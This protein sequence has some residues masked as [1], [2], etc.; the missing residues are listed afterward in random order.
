MLKQPI[1]PNTIALSLLK[2]ESAKREEAE[3]KPPQ[4]DRMSAS[5]RCYRDRWATMQGLP[6]DYGKG[7]GASVLQ[8]FRLGHVIEDE[9]V[10]LL[11]EAGF[12][13][14]DQQREVGE[15]QWIG[16][17]DGIVEW[18]PSGRDWDRVTSLLEI[19]SANAKQFG[20]CQE[21]GYEAWKPQYAAQLHAYMGYIPEVEEALVIV[22]NK[23]TSEIYAER[24]LFDL[25]E[26]ERLKE[27]SRIVTESKTVPVRPKQ[28]TSHGCRFCNWCD[29]NEWCWSPATDV[30]FD[31]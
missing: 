26:F 13:V 2:N 29:R 5:G 7:F 10:D 15:G 19:K 21:L 14:S 24:I 23:N 25:D 22:Y 3:R 12:T 17:I 16:H 20:L 28:A 18:S 27:Q 1:I 8:I 30:E 9:V 31:E 11:G 4:V 6:L